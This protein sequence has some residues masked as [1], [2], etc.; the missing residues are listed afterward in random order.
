MTLRLTITGLAEM[1]AQLT[2][3]DHDLVERAGD[4]AGDAIAEQTR[5][6]L[7]SGKAS[8]S[9]SP[10]APWRDP[11]D[12]RPGE[13]LLESSGA[14]LRSI[15]SQL[16]GETI[17]VGSPLPY[18]AAQQFGSARRGLP[19]RPF[20]GLSP[21]NRAAIEQLVLGHFEEALA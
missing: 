9:G 3:L 17:E 2:E 20:L 18:A 14:L 13:E 15:R 11:D 16:D 4:A 12:H 1:R 6:R 7:A 21:A 5:E 8:P 19:A 10:W